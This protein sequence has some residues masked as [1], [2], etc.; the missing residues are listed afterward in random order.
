MYKIWGSKKVDLLVRWGVVY[1]PLR[2]PPLATAM[3]IE[4]I[5]AKISL[6]LKAECKMTILT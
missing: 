1:R 5:R 2:P 4:E 3:V 6:T